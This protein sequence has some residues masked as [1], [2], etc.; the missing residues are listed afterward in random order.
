MSTE[1]WEDN[2]LEPNEVELRNKYRI[3]EENNDFTGIIPI[4]ATS[5]NEIADFSSSPF[6]ERYKYC[7]VFTNELFEKSDIIGLTLPMFDKNW[8][9]E[10]RY[11]STLERWSK[12]LPVDPPTIIRISNKKIHFSDGRHRMVLSKIL[13]SNKMFVSCPIHLIDEISKLITIIRY[14]AYDHK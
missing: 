2:E 14:S 12:Q 11:I 3:L 6:T 10:Q 4:W 13:K 8:P 1:E 5:I 7:E 9:S